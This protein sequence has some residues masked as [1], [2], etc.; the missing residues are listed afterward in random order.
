MKPLGCHGSVCWPSLPSHVWNMLKCFDLLAPQ[1]GQRGWDHHRLNWINTIISSERRPLY[2][3][4]RPSKSFLL[5]IQD[6]HISTQGNT[7][8]NLQN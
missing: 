2:H 8:V 7:F 6:R 1:R 3:I 5:N 4:T